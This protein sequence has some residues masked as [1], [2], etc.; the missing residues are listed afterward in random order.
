V[1][2]L[3]VEGAAHVEVESGSVEVV[4]LSVVVVHVVVNSAAAAHAEQEHL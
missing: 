1:V 2:L 4:V 3:V